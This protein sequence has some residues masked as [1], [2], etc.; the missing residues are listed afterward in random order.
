MPHKSY[1]KLHASTDTCPR[2][3]QSDSVPTHSPATFDLPTLPPSDQII[4]GRSTKELQGAFVS[5]PINFASFSIPKSFPFIID[6]RTP[7][8]LHPNKFGLN[9]PAYYHTQTSRLPTIITTSP[10]TR[11]RDTTT[12][13]Q[14]HSQC[15]IAVLL[16]HVDAQSR[17]A[18]EN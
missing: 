1:P 9:C 2:K 3:P 11:N 8:L 14:P 15:L 12:Q 4:I 18:T 17:F 13:T 5:I 6:T 16:H 7:P 10:S